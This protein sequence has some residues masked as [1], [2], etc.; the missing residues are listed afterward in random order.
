MGIRKAKQ[1]EIREVLIKDL[2]LSPEQVSAAGSLTELKELFLPPTCKVAEIFK[3]SPDDVSI[4]VI[5]ILK[6]KG[7]L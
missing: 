2:G 7:G 6:E 3:G 5:D 1:K 4:K